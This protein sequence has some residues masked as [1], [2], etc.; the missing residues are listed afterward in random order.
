[1]LTIG[2]TEQ[3]YTLW[4]VGEPYPAFYNQY[5]YDMKQDI[6]YYQ[7]LSLDLEEA[8]KK[9]EA[10]YPNE[11]YAID[12]MLRGESG[13]YTRTLNGERLSNA[14]D[15]MFSFGKLKYQDIRIADDVWQLTRAYGSEK[16]KRTRLYARKRLIELGEI[17]RYD[18][19]QTVNI[20]I[21]WG[22]SG[23]PE[24]YQDVQYSRKY[25]TLDQ[26]EEIEKEINKP[27]SGHYEV[28]GAKV[29]LELK[30]IE[31]FGFNGNFGYTYIC[32][33]ADINNRE[34]KYMGSS[35]SD[36]SKDTF[37]KVQ[38]TITHD[39]YKGAETKLKRIKILN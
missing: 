39:N 19:V 21:N 8:K 38:A 27:T 29:I 17:V 13:S 2:F 6:N 23:M 18:W 25:A 22:K 20:N 9:V 33:Y 4:S 14:P 1:M 10:K 7:N 24:N 37:T 3:Y 15:W 16:N 5:E 31:S 11:K 34:F 28:D 36:I 35:P 30:E 26:I 12:L 32:I